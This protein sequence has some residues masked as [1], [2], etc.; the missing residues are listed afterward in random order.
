MVSV[1]KYNKL[2][3]F[4]SFKNFVRRWKR[5]HDEL[6]ALR[7]RTEDQDTTKAISEWDAYC[8]LLPQCAY[9][10]DA[11]GEQL[12]RFVVKM[13]DLKSENPKP[14][15]ALL[16]QVLKKVWAHKLCHPPFCLY[17]CSHHF[18]FDKYLLEQALFEM[19]HSNAR[20]SKK[21]SWK[22]Y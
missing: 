22:S 18:R 5:M 14:S 9:T 6:Q 4:E 21:E 11:N 3:H 20:K 7:L 10:H 17:D 2:G 8:H 1:Y 16:P 12:V 13:E 19:P 15:D